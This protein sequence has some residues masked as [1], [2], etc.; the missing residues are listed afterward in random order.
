MIN[1]FLDLDNVKFDTSFC[2]LAYL[3]PDIY[4]FLFWRHI[5]RHLCLKC[6]FGGDPVVR[7]RETFSMLFSRPNTPENQH[8]TF[9]CYFLGVMW[10][11]YPTN[12][13]NVPPCWTPS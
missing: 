4:G 12:Y 11:I 8:K 10:H 6:I 7:F 5:G 13:D 3:W 2:Y 1:R 9:S